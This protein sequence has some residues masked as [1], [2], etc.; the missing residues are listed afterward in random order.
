MQQ[1]GLSLPKEK[2]L[3]GLSEL[4]ATLTPVWELEQ[5]I[6]TPTTG[7]AKLSKLQLWLCNLEKLK[8]LLPK[9]PD[10]AF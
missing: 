2:V 3:P 6:K 8:K 5:A 4:S 9:Y 7:P 10:S 1:V